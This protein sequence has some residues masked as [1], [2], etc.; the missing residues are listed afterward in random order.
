MILVRLFLCALEDH[1]VDLENRTEIK[2]ALN[3]PRITKDLYANAFKSGLIEAGFGFAS[4]GV[5]QGLGTLGPALAEIVPVQQIS[6]NL[7]QSAARLFP[8]FSQAAIKTA[9]R[10]A[11]VSAVNAA[12][13]AI[14]LIGDRSV[15]SAG[16]VWK[17]TII[18]NS[19]TR[20]DDAMRGRDPE[21]AAAIFRARAKNSITNGSVHIDYV[22]EADSMPIWAQGKIQDH[23][24][25]SEDEDQALGFDIAPTA[26]RE[27]RKSFPTARFA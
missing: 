14:S 13:S 17:S 25:I 11:T 1:G 12:T 26:I 3:E 27:N 24:R 8:N 6:D 18:Q 9:T 16:R 2:A 15:D 10:E 20:V 23:A 21:K 4:F 7:T 5:G 19:K 22:G